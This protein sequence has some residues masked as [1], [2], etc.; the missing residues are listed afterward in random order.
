[1]QSQIHQERQPV[2][3]FILLFL[4]LDAAQDLQEPVHD[5][6]TQHLHAESFFERELLENGNGKLVEVRASWMN[7]MIN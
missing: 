1:M 3:Q 5:A 6:E 2:L 7:I 4:W